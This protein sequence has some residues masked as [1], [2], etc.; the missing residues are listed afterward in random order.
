MIRYFVCVLVFGILFNNCKE[1]FDMSKESLLLVLSKKGNA[2]L[3]RN[4]QEIPIQVSSFVMKGDTIRTGEASGVDLEF[5][6]GALLRIKEKS[7][8][9]I[10]SILSQ[11]D[12]EIDIA[13]DRGK[14]FSKIKNKLKDKEY[15]RIRTPTMTAGVRGTEFSVS[16]E[17]IPKVMVLEG[18]VSLEKESLPISSVKAGKKAE[19]ESLEISDLSPEEKKELE[20]DSMSLIPPTTE[21]KENSQK[22]LIDFKESQKSLIESQ[23]T[24]NQDELNEEKERNQ[25]ELDSQKDSNRENL[26]T[27]KEK[28]K[29]ELNNQT[30]KDKSNLNQQ[31]ESGKNENMNIKSKGKDAISGVK[32]ETE[33]EKEKINN[34]KNSMDAIKNQN[35]LESVKPK[36]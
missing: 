27:Q 30:G 10:N 7:T 2:L 26:N 32:K 18:E 19:G 3:L 17:D 24:K 29:E 34:T 13:L 14:I 6:N 31:I 12:T 25:N 36:K 15:F 8:V 28:N 35:L 20:A 23:K 33:A 1:R 9:S 22:L 21:F 4:N 11:E 16:E 5:P